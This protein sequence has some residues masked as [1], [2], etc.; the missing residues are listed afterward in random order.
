MG[1]DSDGVQCLIFKEDIKTKTNLGGLDRC[2]IQPRTTFVYI[3][4]NK[5]C[6]PVHLFEKY[7]SLCPK[8]SKHEE[9][10]LH[11]MLKPTPW[12]W[13]ADKPI[14]INALC[15]TVKCLA[16]HAGLEGKFSNHSLCG[17]SAMHLF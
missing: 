1:K 5:Q 14:G 6:C 3:Y 12:Q 17:S 7:I 4:E 13:F 15:Q 10:Y 2:E 16:K 11:P 8:I 9:F